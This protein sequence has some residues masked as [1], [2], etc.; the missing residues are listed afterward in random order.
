MHF[1]YTHVDCVRLLQA[2]HPRFQPLGRLGPL[3][4]Y[5]APPRDTLGHLLAQPLDHSQAIIGIRRRHHHGHDHPQGVDQDLPLAPLDL[6]AAVNAEVLALGRRLEALRVHAASGGFGRSASPPALPLAQGLH[7]AG[8][9]AVS[10]PA[11]AIAL[12]GAPVAQL[13]GHQTP[14]AAR[15]VEGQAAVEHTSHVARRSSGSAGA[16]GAFRQH[17]WEPLPL[18]IGYICGIF[19]REAHG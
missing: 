17:R 1:V 15:L 11:R 12:E 10:S 9:D 8:P 16:P 6:F 7:H 19:S 14:W 18:R 13:L 4:P 5:V 2:S 3:N